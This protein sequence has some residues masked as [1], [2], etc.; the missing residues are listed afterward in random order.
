MV[1]LTALLPS[2]F[3]DD[4]LVIRECRRCG[5]TLEADEDVCPNCDSDA[6]VTYTLNT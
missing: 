2:V 1:D 5:T 6:V 4:P 3:G